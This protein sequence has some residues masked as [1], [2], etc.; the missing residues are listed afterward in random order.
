MSGKVFSSLE[1]LDF[2]I[3]EEKGHTVHRPVKKGQRQLTHD[4]SR[5]PKAI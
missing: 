1:N 3:M 4:P 5:H 2:T